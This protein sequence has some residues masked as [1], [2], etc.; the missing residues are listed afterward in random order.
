[1]I[2]LIENL[3]LTESRQGHLPEGKGMAA[4]ENSENGDT[5]LFGRESG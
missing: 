1:M 5:G 3:L 2:H 4:F